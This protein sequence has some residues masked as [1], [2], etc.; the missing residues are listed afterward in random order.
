MV[1]NIS[2]LQSKAL[3]TFFDNLLIRHRSSSST[4]SFRQKDWTCSQEWWP[5]TVPQQVFIS[6]YTA[7]L[8]KPHS[9]RLHLTSPSGEAAARAR[10]DRWTQKRS[11][12]WRIW[13]RGWSATFLLSSMSTQATSTIPR[14]MQSV[15]L[16]NMFHFTFPAGAS[17]G[18]SDQCC[19]LH[20]RHLWDP[21]GIQLLEGLLCSTADNCWRLQISGCIYKQSRNRCG[22]VP[23]TRENTW[24]MRWIGTSSQGFF[25]PPPWS[26]NCPPI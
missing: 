11:R 4:I 22:T 23:R 3:F 19:F 2:P 15:F 12:Q 5:C 9:T 16:E 6:F 14:W 18:V 25:Y 1:P 20:G 26:Q 24:R 8:K 7:L 21:G 17:S 13:R 10:E